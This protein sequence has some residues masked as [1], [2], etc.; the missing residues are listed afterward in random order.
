MARPITLQEA[1]ENAADILQA[2]VSAAALRNR[3]VSR[4]LISSSGRVQR[5]RLAARA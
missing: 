1:S 2:S 5:G 3:D 4:R